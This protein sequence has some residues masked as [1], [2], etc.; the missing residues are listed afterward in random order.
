MVCLAFGACRA[1]GAAAACAMVQVAELNVD[2]N[3]SQFL[4][5][6]VIDGKPAQMIVDTGAW[7]SS[8]FLESAKRLGLDP[9]STRATFYGAGGASPVWL[10]TL[11][12]L[13]LGGLTAHDMPMFVAGRRSLGGDG[14][15]GASFLLQTDV[16]FDLGHG[17]IRFF[18]PRGCVG[19]QVVYWGQAYA[20]APMEGDQH[21][22][23]EVPVRVNGQLVTA[24]MDTG[25]G[26]SVLTPGV[27]RTAG[28]NP[29]SSAVTSVGA[30][31]GI[32]P[33]AIET[34]V[35]VFSSFSFG[36]ETIHNARLQIADVFGAGKETTT[37]SNVPTLRID[38]PE[39][40]LGADFFRAHRVYIAS[41]QRKVYVSYEGGPVFDVQGAVHPS[42]PPAPPS[43]A[44]DP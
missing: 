28:V 3:R 16:E 11:K 9:A 30:S 19:D 24:Q 35:G 27:A 41:S 7:T 18:K 15:L 23:I 1:G 44:P 36:D 8:L 2:Q 17:K 6:A 20:V 37:G 4:L 39:M 40:L 29:D 25:A 31:H 14:L 22:K 12:S 21:E 34:Y 38:A 32:G 10:I 13:Q 33:K 42:S 43:A 26:R 5:P